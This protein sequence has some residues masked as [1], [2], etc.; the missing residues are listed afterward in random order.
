MRLYIYGDGGGVQAPAAYNVQ[1]WNGR[2]WIDATDQKR[3]PV[4]PLAS[5]INTVTFQPVKTSKVRIVFTHSDRSFSGLTEL[6]V[7][8]VGKHPDD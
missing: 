1:T 8:G 4:K 2:D 5:A 7:W 3:S 6:E